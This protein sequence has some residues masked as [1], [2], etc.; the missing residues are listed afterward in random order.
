MANVT[1]VLTEQYW[2][3]LRP[4]EAPAERFTSLARARALFARIMGQLTGVHLGQAQLFVRQAPARAEE[5]QAAGRKA[6]EEAGIQAIGTGVWRSDEEQQGRLTEDF[7]ETA[8]AGL[9]L[10]QRSAAPL[11]QAGAAGSSKASRTEVAS[12]WPSPRSD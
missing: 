8:Q 10:D 2:S 9:E 1:Y 3:E 6:A 7:V 5:S 12:A 11:P 4:A